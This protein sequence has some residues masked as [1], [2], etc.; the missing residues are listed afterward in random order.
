MTAAQVQALQK[1]QEIMRE[2]FSAGVVTVIGEME[3]DDKRED[4]QSLWHGG[5]A[6]AYGL[7]Y[8]GSQQLDRATKRR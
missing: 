3:N 7:Y 6:T 5:A 8:L 2:H 4:I 1:M